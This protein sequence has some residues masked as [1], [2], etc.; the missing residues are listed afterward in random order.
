[1]SQCLIFCRTNLDCLNLHTFF[2]QCNRADSSSGTVAG[3]AGVAVGGKITVS[4]YE[5]RVLGSMLSQAERREHLQLFKQQEIRLL[6]CTDV[7]ARGLDIDSLPYVINMT[8]PD[9]PE[10]YLHRIGRVGRK[11]AYG[12]AIS[13]VHAMSTSKEE[14]V[15]FH[16]CKSRGGTINHHRYTCTDRINCSISYKE[17]DMFL[18]IQ[19]H[20]QEEI[21]CLSFNDYQLPEKL[22]LMNIQYGEMSR[23]DLLLGNNKKDKIVM[24]D[25]MKSRVK[26]LVELELQAQNYFL[27]VPQSLSGIYSGSANHTNNRTHSHSHSGGNVTVSSSTAA[28]LK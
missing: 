14:K 4:R 22:A 16:T 19:K 9:E 18:K 15:W 11:Q 1:M 3:G 27:S 5:S 24:T 17:Y 28:E 25:Q 26:Q 10:S 8:L 2:Q 23:A 6:I 7:A 21:L 20:I 13:L 12:L